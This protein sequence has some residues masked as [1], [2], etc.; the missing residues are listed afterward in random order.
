MALTLTD[1]P[2]VVGDTDP[3]PTCGHVK[4]P[5]VRLHEIACCGLESHEVA[6][7]FLL[8][9]M[10]WALGHLWQDENVYSA[11]KSD[12]PISETDALAW[13]ERAH[14]G[15]VAKRPRREGHTIEFDRWED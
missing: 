6:T 8:V 3:C 4:Q 7:D 12:R 2:A 9:E 5:A 10:A 11:V 14:A 13:M 15:E 1:A